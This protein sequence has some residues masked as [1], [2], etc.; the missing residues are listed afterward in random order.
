MRVQTIAGVA[1]L[2]LVSGAQ[3]ATLTFY[4]TEADFL[5][6]TSSQ[7]VEDYEGLPNAQHSNAEMD[8]YYGETKYESTAGAVSNQTWSGYYN[9]TN[10]SFRLTF[11][12]TSI[13]TGGG[14]HAVGTSFASYDSRWVY[15]LH[16]ADGTTTEIA[17]PT[18]NLGSEVFVG[19]S[20]DVPIVS[21]HMCVTGD[22]PSILNGTFWLDTLTLGAAAPPA[23]VGDVDGDNDTDVL[24]FGTL[25]AAFGS[26]SVDADYN[27]AADLDGS[28]AV[29]VLDFAM[30]ATDFGCTP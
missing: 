18:A 6:A 4:A 8:A 12:E 27:P 29:D 7:I 24:D 5:A 20:S 21:L 23:C 15:F 30:L 11:D 22:T 25:A 3:G 13:T 28:G 2:C 16:F 14:V 10:S 1:G 17:L 19:F 9:A 26:T